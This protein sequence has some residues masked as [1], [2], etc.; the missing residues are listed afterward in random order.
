[1]KLNNYYKRAASKSTVAHSTGLS[2]YGRPEVRA[3][4][5]SGIVVHAR[6]LALASTDIALYR[7]QTDCDPS[8]LNTF[9]ILGKI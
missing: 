9:Q 5:F 1:M 2:V 4:G 7:I 3:A 8:F 6:R